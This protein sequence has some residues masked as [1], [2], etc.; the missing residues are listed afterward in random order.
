MSGSSVFPPENPKKN[1][2]GN[3]IFL[4]NNK[5]ECEDIVQPSSE[6]NLITLN[7]DC[8]LTKVRLSPVQ[9]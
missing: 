8:L 3:V 9:V 6:E 2:K 7:R 1:C 5:A 4:L